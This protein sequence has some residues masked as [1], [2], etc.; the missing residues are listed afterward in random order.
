MDFKLFQNHFLKKLSFLTELLLYLCL[1]SVDQTCM[2]L[3]LDSVFCSIDLFVCLNAS[4]TL[5]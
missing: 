3:F 4:A 1:K 2:S 5:S